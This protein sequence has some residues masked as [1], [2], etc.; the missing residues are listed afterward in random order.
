MVKSLVRVTKFGIQNGMRYIHFPCGNKFVTDRLTFS[1]QQAR[2]LCPGII[3]IPY[4]FERYIQLPLSQ[5][6]ISKRYFYKAINSCPC[7]STP[8]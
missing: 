6:T 7:R 3:T 1:L 2:Q 5:L 4:E 8:F